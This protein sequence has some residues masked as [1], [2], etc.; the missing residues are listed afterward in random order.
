MSTEALVAADPQIILLGDGAYG[1]TADAVAAR[2]GWNVL[3]AVKDGAITPVDDIVVTRPGPR[4]VDGLLALTKAV[5]PDAVL[6]S[7]A[8]VDAVARWSPDRSRWRRARPRLAGRARR[9]RRPV[10][11]RRRRRRAAAR[12]ARPRR[13][14]GHGGRR[15]GRHARDPRPPAARAGPGPDLDRGVRDHRHGPAA[16]AGPDDDARRGGAR[17][18]RRDLPGAAAQPAWPT[19][20]CSARRRAPPSAR[21]S[22]C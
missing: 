1:V 2:P 8:P 12:R 9:R 5:H 22:P 15:P 14:D 3:T 20:T 13:R 10:V 16:A 11:H 7:L 21:P 4:L 18:R 17:R 6:P 19:R